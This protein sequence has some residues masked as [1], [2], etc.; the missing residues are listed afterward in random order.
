MAFKRVED[1]H[2]ETLIE[3]FQSYG[4]LAITVLVTDYNSLR[5]L[6]T[7]TPI[8]PPITMSG[9]SGVL[10]S[11]SLADGIL[12]DMIASIFS[13]SCLSTGT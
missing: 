7:N 5:F 2:E 6:S 4:S 1:R 12:A 13:R 10:G 11:V 8:S 9:F 3:I